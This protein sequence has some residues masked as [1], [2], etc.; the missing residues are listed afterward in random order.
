MTAEDLQRLKEV[1]SPIASRYG[2]AK[3]SLFGSR[4]RGEERSDSD[5]D[6]WI[7]KG[8]LRGL[9]ALGGLMSDLEN[10]LGA[11]V[12]IIV[13]SCHDPEIMKEV[14]NDEVLLYEQTR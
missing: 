11:E 12:D 14:R 4:S 2:I 7:S 8:K 6:F 10:A 9:F 3:M 13:D 1:V 5:Y